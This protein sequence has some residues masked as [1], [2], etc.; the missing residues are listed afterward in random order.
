MAISCVGRRVCW[1]ISIGRFIA[2]ATP[3]RSL[4]LS[5]ILLSSPNT[6]LFLTLERSIHGFSDSQGLFFVAQTDNAL[7]A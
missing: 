2:V 4:S 1:I 6:R 7:G 5:C 3:S